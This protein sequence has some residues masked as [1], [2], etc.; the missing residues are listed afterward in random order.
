MSDSER[1]IDRRSVLKGLG[2]AAVLGTVGTAAFAGSG[3]AQSSIDVSITGAEIKNDAGDVDWIGVEAEKTI[4]WDGFDVPVDY[5]AFKHEITIEDGGETEWH[6]LYDNNHEIAHGSWKTPDPNLLNWSGENGSDGWGGAGEYVSEYT[7]SD[8]DL[9][10]TK[11]TAHANIKWAV[12]DE[13]QEADDAERWYSVQ[14]AAPW[15][16]RLSVDKDGKQT[17]HV[18]KWKT[19][20]TYYTDAYDT[21]TPAKI[22]PDD[23]DPTATGTERFGIT[24]TNEAATTG[25]TNSNGSATAE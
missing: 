9:N 3:A 16:E 14:E 11:G 18:L 20:L 21:D 19:T 25:E 4:K 1:S 8:D 24:V 12:I 6:T 13:G 22:K 5:I 23:G 10:G 2:G 17:K 15:A 7:S